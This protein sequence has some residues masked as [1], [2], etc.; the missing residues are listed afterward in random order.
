MEKPKDLRKT[1]AVAT[2]AS[3]PCLQLSTALGSGTGLAE[4]NL[5]LCSATRLSA[6]R[7]NVLA[8]LLSIYN[9]HIMGMNVVLVDK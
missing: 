3:K 8:F 4:L 1:W 2:E 6:E 5:G 7:H 9:I